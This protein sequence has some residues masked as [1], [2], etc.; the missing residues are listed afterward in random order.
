MRASSVRRDLRGEAGDAVVAGVDRHQRGGF[1]ADRLLVVA[2][3]R[4]V[5]R[6][7]LDQ[8]DAGRAHHVGHAERAADLD[9]FPARDHH[10]APRRKRR[11]HQQHGSG[12]VVDHRRGFGPGQLAQQLF[13][14]RVAIAAPA[15]GKVELQRAGLAHRL[16]GLRHGLLGQQRAAEIGVQHRAGE[17]EHRL[18]RGR[19]AG[20]KPR[21]S[22]GDEAASRRRRRQ[23]SGSSSIAA[24]TAATTAVW[25]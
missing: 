25:P 17:V 8:P 1:R 2:R 24:R 12:V 16:G 11:Q 22:V 21:Q 20:G 15:G 13:D 5:G 19:V 18:Q 14:Q 3:V 6:A 4:A 10:F 23:L 9:Q 7:D